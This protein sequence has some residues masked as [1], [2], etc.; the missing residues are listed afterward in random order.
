MRSKAKAL[1]AKHEAKTT[2]PQYFL[3]TIERFRGKQM[4]GVTAQVAKP[5]ARAE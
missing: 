4:T 5:A 1:E 2:K 3:V